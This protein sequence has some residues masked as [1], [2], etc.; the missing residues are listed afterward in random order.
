MTL[1]VYVLYPLSYRPE[2]RADW[3]RL[4]SEEFHEVELFRWSD[5]GGRAAEVNQ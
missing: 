4:R 2:D 1:G 5:G 3:I